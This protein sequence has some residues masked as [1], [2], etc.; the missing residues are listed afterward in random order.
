MD[1]LGTNVFG[2]T[3]SANNLHTSLPV[4]MSKNTKQIGTFINSP[5]KQSAM[6]GFTLLDSGDAPDS[7]GDANHMISTNSQVVQPF[8]GTVRGDMDYKLPDEADN[9]WN[10]DEDIL[11]QD[12]DISKHDEGPDQLMPQTEKNDNYT[13]HR[14]IIDSTY[15]LKFVASANGPD[16]ELRSNQLQLGIQWKNQNL[17]SEQAQTS[18]DYRE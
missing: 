8:I 10:R 13:N 7:Y 15:Q 2:P 16:S 4:V 3:N 18:P 6:V 14:N 12:E 11:K 1:G 9:F 5:G 17:S